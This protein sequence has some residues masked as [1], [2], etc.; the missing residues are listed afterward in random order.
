M[1]EQFTHVVIRILFFI[2]FALLL[3]YC[4]HQAG[5]IGYAVFSDAPYNSSQSAPEGVITVTDGEKLLDITKD[6]EKAGIVKNAY[7]TALTFR[8]MEGYDQIRPGEYVLRASMKP[9]EIMR[10]LTGQEDDE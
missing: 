6:M 2:F 5:E 9:S 1:L 10:T 3:A 8:T 4:F 7:V